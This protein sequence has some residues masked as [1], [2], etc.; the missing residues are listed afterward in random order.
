MKTNNETGQIIVILAL[1]LVA[2]IGITAVAADGSMV[3]NERREDQSIADSVA[4][5]GA[6]RAANYLKDKVVT[7][8]FCGKQLGT[9]ATN[10]ALD[11]AYNFALSSYNDDNGSPLA[12]EKNVAGTENGILVG[13]GTDDVG[14]NYLDVTTVITSTTDTFFR[15]VITDEELTT[16]VS[17]TARVYPKKPF[18]WG[19][20]LVT[21]SPQCSNKVG[22]MTFEGGSNVL[23]KNAGILS[24]SCIKADA[25][26]IHIE[27]TGPQ[28]SISYVPSSVYGT[29]YVGCKGCD[30]SKFSPLPQPLSEAPPLIKLDPPKCTNAAY[31]DA[32]QSGVLY[33]G[34]YNGI[35]SK[36][37]MELKPGLYCLKGGFSNDK[38][39]FKGERVT[40]YFLNSATVSLNDNSK[41]GN[42][43][44][45]TAPDCETADAGCGVPPAIRGLLM[46]FAKPSTIKINGNSANIFEGTIFAPTSEATLNGGSTTSTIK[47]QIV[48][49]FIKVD[50]GALLEMNL[51]GA[52][53][54][55]EPAQIELLR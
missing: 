51:E 53:L 46:Y 39:N 21:V 2:I 50:G 24:Y 8:N 32:P 47:T 9:D 30:A 44:I 29:S 36:G 38:G 17:S 14:R 35:N 22:G 1:A 45:L 55:Q 54:Y 16:S 4:M 40:L 48:V 5:A 20:G 42:Y 33:P 27:S 10:A 19:N 26:N 28:K 49:S 43:L 7:E 12:L 25:S 31:V 18:A 37:D 6:G 3:Y 15:Q 34:N 13:C 11:G 52:E 41:K 23:V